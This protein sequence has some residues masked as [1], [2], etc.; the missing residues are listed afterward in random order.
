MMVC[1]FFGG[2]SLLNKASSGGQPKTLPFIIS[3]LITFPPVLFTIQIKNISQESFMTKA[4][5]DFIDHLKLRGF[6]Q[7]T[8]E[9]YIKKMLHNSPVT[10]KPHRI[11][12]IMN[13]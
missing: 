7:R 9:N 12:L 3:L 1:N 4:R 8:I 6:S 11:Y 13:M 2:L 10:T 5:Q